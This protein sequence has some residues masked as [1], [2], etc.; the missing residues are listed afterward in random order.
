VVD[1]FQQA[2]GQTGAVPVTWDCSRANFPFANLGDALGPIVVSVLAGLPVQHVPFK[3]RETRLCSI[4]TI[5][6]KMRSGPVH[7]WG[8]GVDARRNAMT[9][10]PA[11]FCVPPETEFVVHAVR[12]PYSR[13]TFERAS[14]EAPPVYGDPAWFLP[15]MIPPPGDKKYELGV[16]L[17]VSELMERH[18][19]S[20]PRPEFRRYHVP[21]LLAESVKIIGTYHDPT[22]TALR[23]KLNEILACKRIVSTSFHGMMLADAYRIPCAFFS[24]QRGGGT[25]LDAFDDR[26]RLD[27][28]FADFYAGSG[29]RKVPAYCQDRGTPTDWDD[30]ISFI[31]RCWEPVDNDFA[32]LLGAFPLPLAVDPARMD[33][34]GSLSALETFTL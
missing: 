18:P 26:E 2:V 5:V 13:A 32:D 6:H 33:W 10:E 11:D 34:N 12:G 20:S 9:P 27:H 22:L 16:V 3:S 23:C 8:T 30:V 14:V 29:R 7:V 24:L 25:M 21:P 31:D 15:R 4:G 28:R 19:L 17:H 1:D